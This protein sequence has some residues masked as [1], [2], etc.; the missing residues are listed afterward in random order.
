MSKRYLCDLPPCKNLLPDANKDATFALVLPLFYSFKSKKLH[1]NFLVGSAMWAAHS[2]LKHTDLSELNSRIIFFVE[3]NLWHGESALFQQ[4][5]FNER[6]VVFFDAPSN[7]HIEINR[8]SKKLWVLSHPQMQKYDRILLWD[9]DLFAARTSNDVPCYKIA[10]E[11]WYKTDCFG[12]GVG[13]MS[14]SDTCVTKYDEKNHWWHKFRHGNDNRGYRQLA[15]HMSELLAERSI[16][17][18]DSTL[19]PDISGGVEYFV[20]SVMPKGF[21]DFCIDAEPRIGDDENIL[22]LWNRLT[23]HNYTD[24]QESWKVSNAH[25]MWK[26][27]QFKKAQEEQ[28]FYFTHIYDEIGDDATWH[29]MWREQVGINENLVS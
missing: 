13:V 9:C 21:V 6:D 4:F 23:G 25:V 27:D 5:G 10:S 26:P 19:F 3:T 22:H 20:R 28:Q 17:F 7:S 16:L 12:G 14:W 11:L 29:H 18:D 15:S 24:L 1:N 8:V 2:M